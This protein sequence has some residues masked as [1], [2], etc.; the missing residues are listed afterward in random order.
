MYC[1]L[2]IIYSTF[3][4]LKSSRQLFLY[5]CAMHRIRLQRFRTVL[6]NLTVEFQFSKVTKREISLGIPPVSLRN[7]RNR[8]NGRASK[9]CGTNAVSV[10]PV[11]PDNFT[12]PPP[13][14]APPRTKS[15]LEHVEG[16]KG[17]SCVIFRYRCIHT[18]R[19]A[20]GTLDTSN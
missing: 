4:L 1:A 14:P 5:I 19:M 12:I 2:A 3:P 16:R 20:C 15:Y 17:V 6:S 8:L 11:H 13:L 7:Y 18:V 10:A 9:P